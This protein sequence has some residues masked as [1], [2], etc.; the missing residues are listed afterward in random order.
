[1]NISSINSGIIKRNFGQRNCVRTGF[2]Q[3]AA[4]SDKCMKK[5]KV[6]H[7]EMREMAQNKGLFNNLY[8]RDGVCP[9]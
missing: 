4:D 7:S 8:L 2:G 9:K 1:M 3:R 5:R 6:E